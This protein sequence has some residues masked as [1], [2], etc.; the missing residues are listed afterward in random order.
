MTE[1]KNNK[2]AN[3]LRKRNR[4]KNGLGVSGKLP[5]LVVYRSNKHIYAQV[6]DDNESVTL[7]SSGSNNKNL[8]S[9]IAKAKSKIEKSEIVGKNLAEKLN[10]KNIKKLVFDRNGYRFHG[11]VKAVAD[12]IR[13]AGIII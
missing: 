13:H 9:K 4:I 10:D 1:K 7:V 8:L 3:W 6:V 11:R 12:S 5:R 2:R